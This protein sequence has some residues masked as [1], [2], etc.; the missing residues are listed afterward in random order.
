MAQDGKGKKR[1]DRPPVRPLPDD[2]RLLALH[3][4]FVRNAEKLGR[5]YE[6]SKDWGKARAVYEEILKLVP[7]YPPAQ[8]K[9]AEMLERE[10][11]AKTTMVTIRA[12]EGWQDTGVT[13]LA[14]KPV[15]ITASGSWVFHLKVETNA[16]GLA[17]PK[18]LRDFNPGCL[19]GMIV[20]NTPMP[21]ASKSD[22]EKEIAPF[23]VGSGKQ[24]M[25]NRSGRLYL[26]MY[27]TN[28]SDNEGAL[29]VEI[30]GTFQESK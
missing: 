30:R 13:V 22:K 28:P 25:P 26:R 8:A 17:I 6:G 3:L 21:S 9:L 12:N 18:E 20:G 27:D 19:I 2:K 16:E 29:K 1:D 24:M 7:Q 4:E 11:A 5:E 14:G 15:S 10:S 23:V